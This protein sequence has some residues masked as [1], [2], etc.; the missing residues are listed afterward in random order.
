LLRIVAGV[1]IVAV[2][3]AALVFAW[4]TLLAFFVLAGV[5]AAIAGLFGRGRRRPG[6]VTIEGE[7]RRVE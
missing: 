2:L 4:I 3:V 7:S 6:P 5:V 1:A